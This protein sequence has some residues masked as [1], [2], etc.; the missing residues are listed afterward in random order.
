MDFSG[1]RFYGEK[2]GFY[3]F[4]N[5]ENFKFIHL[6]LM[7]WIYKTVEKFKFLYEMDPRKQ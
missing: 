4:L 5:V 6:Y 1:K 3:F 2:P 7:R